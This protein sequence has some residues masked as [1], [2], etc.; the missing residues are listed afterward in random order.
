MKKKTPISK[1]I[2][3]VLCII[4]AAL[5]AEKD[6][7]KFGKID[8][9][10]LEMKVY[11]TDSSAAA[12][13]LCDFGYFNSNTFQF[14][15]ILRVK[16][17]KKEGMNWG[18]QIFNL[19]SDVSIKGIT[20]NLENGEIVQTKLKSESIFKENVTKASSRKRVAMPNVK[21]GSVIDIQFV[22]Y[23][24]PS[25]WKFQQEIPVRWSELVIEPSQY[26]RFRKNYFGFIP[27]TINTESRSVAKDMP[28]FKKEPYMN[29]SENFISK[30]EIELLNISIPGTE[31]SAG[32]YK[33]LSTTWEAV[34]HTLLEDDNFGKAMQN[35]PFLNSLAKDITKNYS[36]PKERLI[37]AHEAIKK[38]VKWN[39]K[40][41]IASSSENLSTPFKEKIGNSADINLMLIQLLKKLDFEVYPVA[42]STRD[43]GFLSPARPSL[44]KLN[45]VVAYVVLNDEKYFLDATEEFI[46][47]G[48]LPPR[49]INLS[50]RLV[51]EKKSDWV[52]LNNKQIDKRMVNYD[53]KL[54]D[55]DS[56]EGKIFTAK[57][58]IAAFNFRKKYQGFNSKEEFLKDFEKRHK[59]LTVLNCNLTN[60]DSIYMPVKESYDVKIKNGATVAGNQ[61]YINPM[62]Y[63]QIS[64]NPFKS[65]DRKYPVDFVSPSDMTYVLKL[66]LPEGSNVIE[67][68]KDYSAKINDGSAIFQYHA[69]SMGNVILLTYRFVIKRAVYNEAEY[70]DLREL[71]SE[72]VKKQSEQFIIKKS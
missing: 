32:Y 3:L 11:P 44:M 16:I 63:E 51:D 24:L 19:P 29:S 65:E 52:S 31:N 43:N 4:P 61:I 14:T 1:I 9:A 30:Y 48:M 25:D 69:S 38:S 56:F 42:L 39:D 12:A 8:K 58:G 60:L 28:A 26:I 53:L 55:G 20:Y 15:R 49:C 68:P 71:F 50:G 10:D 7:I 72:M 6:P 62:L 33:S 57:Y 21:E 22:Y 41:S 47:A 5:F 54:K 66:E 35:C 36:T 27:L 37:A 2:I 18:N 70:K 13:I 17:L 67:S 23:G 46:P 40:E 64:S 45:Y 59:G 34:N